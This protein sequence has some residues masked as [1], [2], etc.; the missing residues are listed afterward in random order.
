MEHK[1][2]ELRYNRDEV[3][4]EVL[5]SLVDE[6]TFDS[7]LDRKVSQC[8]SPVEASKLTEIVQP[9]P[10]H[11]VEANSSRE[12]S[13]VI[14]VTNPLASS[15]SA[16]VVDKS[17]E[18]KL[19]EHPIVGSYVTE[20]SQGHSVDEE[21]QKVFVQTHIIAVQ[22]MTAEQIIE[23]FHTL[24]RSVFLIRAQQ[25]GLRLALE[26]VL[27]T[28]NYKQ[29]EELLELDRKH[30][31][32]VNRKAKVK[33]EKSGP[34][35]GSAKPSGKGKTRGMKAA[36]TFKSLMMTKEAT[37]DMLKKQNLLDDSTAAYVN[38]SFA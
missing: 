8:I 30:R 1:D 27:S 33:F 2:R 25:Q 15:P 12:T 37:L 4:D 6:P 29:R 36:D 18:L 5:E 3:P 14:P 38:K 17:T 34:S 10:A 13:S 24:D 22:D 28:K 35:T 19:H 32:A 26:D 7:Y 9:E 16:R 11:D 23:R 31:A 21:W 20:H